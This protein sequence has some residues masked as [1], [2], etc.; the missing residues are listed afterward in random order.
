MSEPSS[1]FIAD[2]C[3]GGLSVIKSLWEAGG[4]RDAVF[5]ADYEINP[6]GVKSDSEIAEVVER[7]LN[8]A[9]EQSDTLVIACNTLSIRYHQMRES[10]DQLPR[11]EHVLTMVDCFKTMAE[12]EAVRLANHKVLI[13]GTE[14]TASQDI[15]PEILGTAVPG[16][17]ISTIAATGLERKIAR[18]EPWETYGKP[19]LDNDLFEAIGETDFAVLACTCFP[20]VRSKLQSMFPGVRFIDPGAYCAGLLGKSAS[21]QNAKLQITVTGNVVFNYK[22]ELLAKSY[23]L[24]DSVVF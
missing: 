9:S 17:Q 19:V 14:F 3:I 15:Y 21:P 2:S 7:W 22:V 20:I 8:T 18:F 11:P 12:A 1:V 13:I 5:L 10:L 23:L 24:I 4:A 6:L 16:A